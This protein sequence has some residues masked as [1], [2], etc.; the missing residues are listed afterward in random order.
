MPPSAPSVKGSGFTNLDNAV[1][2][3]TGAK[4]NEPSEDEIYK[5]DQG[6]LDVIQ[7][8]YHSSHNSAA[9]RP[10][11]EKTSPKA[12]GNSIPFAVYIYICYGGFC[13]LFLSHETFF[14]QVGIISNANGTLE[15]IEPVK[16]PNGSGGENFQVVILFIEYLKEKL[17]VWSNIDVF[18]N[19]RLVVYAK[20]V[21]MV[22]HLLKR[23]MMMFRL[24]FNKSLCYEP[25]NSTPPRPNHMKY[26][27]CFVLFIQKADLVLG[28]WQHEIQEGA[29]DWDEDWDKFEEEG[30]IFVKELTLDVQNAIAPPKPKSM[31]VDKEKA[32]TAETPTTASSSVDVNSEDPPSM[33]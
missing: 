7:T 4:F 15:K 14:M 8:N 31:L 18:R 22:I 2:D 28:G 24:L 33:G 29:A 16:L 17:I 3:S 10:Y 23:L 13:T 9:D 1:A 11:S 32:S 27:R 5:K 12:I 6:S 19:C 21:L 20:G 30:Y 26:V 25:K